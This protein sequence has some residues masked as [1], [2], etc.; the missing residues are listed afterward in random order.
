MT[1]NPAKLTQTVRVCP[2]CGG[3]MEQKNFFP[4]SFGFGWQCVLCGFIFRMKS[5]FLVW[6]Y[7]EMG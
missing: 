7:S 6:D 1:K 4:K 5:G 3:H 2:L